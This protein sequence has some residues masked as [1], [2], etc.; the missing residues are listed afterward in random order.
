MDDLLSNIERFR[1]AHNLTERQFG[2]LVLNDHH[3]VDQ[4]RQGRDLRMSTVERVRS[5]MANY[6]PEKLA[7]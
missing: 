2:K 3:F 7:S 1:A 6:S 5:F 4:L